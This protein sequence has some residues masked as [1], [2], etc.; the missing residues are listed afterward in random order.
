MKS[1]N[2]KRPQVTT[3]GAGS[4]AHAVATTTSADNVTRRARRAIQSQP[5]R[6]APLAPASVFAPGG[7]RTRW[8]FTYGCR[9]CGV[10]SVGRARTIEDVP[11]IRRASCRHFVTVMI[12]R[13]YGS[14]Q[15]G[16]AA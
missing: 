13:T 8:T 14:G 11:G 10:Y 4:D 5:G 2:A 12:A 1:R 6:A 7:R 3:P 15:P 9:I 16:A